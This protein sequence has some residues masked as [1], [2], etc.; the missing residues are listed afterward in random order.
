MFSLVAVLIIAQVTV[1]N[2]INVTTILG[3]IAAIGTVTG[4]AVYLLFKTIRQVIKEI[5]DLKLWMASYHREL[6]DA[7][8]SQL[9]A[10]IHR[11]PGHP[12]A[13]PQ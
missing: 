7:Q 8:T 6:T 11:I 2:T 9:E 4:P 10:C 3:I 12:E 1:T 5:Y 13:K